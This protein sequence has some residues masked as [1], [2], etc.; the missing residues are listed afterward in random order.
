MIGRLC[1]L[2]PCAQPHL[3]GRAQRLGS[4][5]QAVAGAEHVGQRCCRCG[6]EGGAHVVR[7]RCVS[8]ALRAAQSARKVAAPVHSLWTLIQDMESLKLTQLLQTRG[9]G[10]YYLMPTKELGL[11][12]CCWNPIQQPFDTQAT[13]EA[14]L[15]ALLQHHLPSTQWNALLTIKTLSRQA[16]K[17]C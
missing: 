17:T 14:W 13:M 16:P 12:C 1:S 15:H 6:P 7:A 10:S 9:A 3:V 8:R 5:R 11:A 4:L 2:T